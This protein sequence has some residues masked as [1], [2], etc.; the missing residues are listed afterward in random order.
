MMVSLHVQDVGHTGQVLHVLSLHMSCVRMRVHV[1]VRV[2]DIR[3]VYGASL[4]TRYVYK[5]KQNN[6][7]KFTDVMF[8]KQNKTKQNKTKQNKTQH[9]T[10]QHN[11]TQHNTTQH[12]TTQHNTTQNTTQQKT[13]QTK[14]GGK[15][16]QN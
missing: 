1:R 3:Q 4:Q 7:S 10:T 11:T 15:I 14:L 8:T 5:T 16:G 6:D 2:F 12:N 9:N 13:K